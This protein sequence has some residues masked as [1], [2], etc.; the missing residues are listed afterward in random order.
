MFMQ[1][2]SLRGMW[3]K[4]AGDDV[5][6]VSSIISCSVIVGVVTCI[7]SILFLIFLLVLFVLLSL[8]FLL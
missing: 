6:T 7:F 3:R 1:V 4:F 2:S 5:F 8:V